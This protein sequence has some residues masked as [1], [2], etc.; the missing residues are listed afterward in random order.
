MMCH[1]TYLNKVK[2]NYQMKFRKQIQILSVVVIAMLIPTTNAVADIIKMEAI[3]TGWNDYDGYKK[4]DN[5]LGTLIE[6]TYFYTGFMKTPFYNDYRL[7]AADEWAEGVDSTVSGRTC[8]FDA[9]LGEVCDAITPQNFILPS[10]DIPEGYVDHTYEFNLEFSIPVLKAVDDLRI[11]ISRQHQFSNSFLNTTYSSGLFYCAP[12][13]D[14]H[15]RL[16]HP[17]QCGNVDLSFTARTVYKYDDSPATN[18]PSPS[19][20]S[21]FALGLMGLMSRRFK[22]QS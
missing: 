9:L 14:G 10:F 22:K 18:V 13:I 7:I 17:G 19:T 1:M 11:Y 6:V 15:R 5:K 12:I 20:L 4:F 16:G 2:W 21:I 8:I 3:S